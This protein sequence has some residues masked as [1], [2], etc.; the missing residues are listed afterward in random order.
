[1]PATP[2]RM[3]LAL[4]FALLLQVVA[5]TEAVAQQYP[6][7]PIRILVGQAVGGGTD[8]LARVVADKLR[9]S[10]KQPVLIDNK[11][12]AA[13]MIASKL[14]AEASPDGYTL[15]AAGMSST[16]SPSLYQAVP[17]DAVNGLQAIAPLMSFPFAIVV[18]NKVPANNLKEFIEFVKKNAA[19]LNVA[20]AGATTTVTA[21]L[22]SQMV[23][24]KFTFI[25]F[26][27]SAPAIVSV[28]SG[29]S[30][31]MFSDLPS[32]MQHVKSGALRA[33]AT[34]GDKRSA[35]APDIPTAREAG[36]PDFVV[37]SWYGM[38]AP[39]RTPT[40]IVTL[41]NAQ[42][43]SIVMQP[44]VIPRLAGMGGEPFTDTVEG[45]SRVYQGDLARWKR[46]I[47][48]GKIPLL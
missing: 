22:F 34:S 3:K 14:A 23:G 39:A 6:G 28:I 44:D 25:P 17:Y 29:D 5:A 24:T 8:L 45:F 13:G 27:G 1:M 2:C 48:Q 11:P 10:L 42:F 36:M 33:I 35:Q 18:N 38:F 26:N 9:D 31:A 37:S 15:L 4:A 46:V 32:A 16:V 20:S 19:G 47:V 12:G 7:K 43:R 41:L 21:E 30:H 40:D